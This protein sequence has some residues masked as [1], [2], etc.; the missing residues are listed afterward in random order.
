MNI[1]LKELQSSTKYACLFNKLKE[2]VYSVHEK[3]PFSAFDTYRRAHLCSIWQWIHFYGPHLSQNLEQRDFNGY[4][5]IFSMATKF[6]KQNNAFVRRK[7]FLTRLHIL[8]QSQ[9]KLTLKLEINWYHFGQCHDIWI[10]EKCKYRIITILLTY[11]YDR[12]NQ[13]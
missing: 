3:G 11:K 8:R 13:V 9:K 10:R 6:E 1:F 12:Q 2:Q 5:N 7:C 4:E